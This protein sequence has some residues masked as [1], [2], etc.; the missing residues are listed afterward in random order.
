MKTR[1]NGRVRCGV[2]AA[3]LI[4]LLMA[5]VS[6]VHAGPP[7]DLETLRSSNFFNVTFNWAGFAL[8]EVPG[9]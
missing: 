2:A 5:A 9:N 8:R 4:G 3:L 7:V 6:D 1:R